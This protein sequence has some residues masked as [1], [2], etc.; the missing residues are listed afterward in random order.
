MS[1]KKLLNCPKVQTRVIDMLI[2]QGVV[3]LPSGYK[4]QYK[5]LLITDLGAKMIKKDNFDESLLDLRDLFDKDFRDDKKLFE[6]HMRD[7][8]KLN[9]Y[10][11]EQ[12]KEAFQ[13]WIDNHQPPYCGKAY[14]FIYR[15]EEGLKLSRLA[16][17]IKSM[18]Q[19]DSNDDDIS[20]KWD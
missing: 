20:V 15:R 13:Y 12:I 9:D 19:S 4:K 5:N 17:T 16:T 8:V 3:G 6:K 10:T 1:L 11:A 18:K 14:K 7:F 2:V